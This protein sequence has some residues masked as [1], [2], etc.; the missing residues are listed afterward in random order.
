MLL[1]PLWSLADGL[2]PPPV[3]DC[4]GLK[5]AEPVFPLSSS[6]YVGWGLLGTHRSLVPLVVNQHVSMEPEASGTRQDL[7]GTMILSKV[8][9][10]V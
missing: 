1:H 5:L 2:T 3:P 6:L 4:R 8:L 9:L 7:Q 10:S